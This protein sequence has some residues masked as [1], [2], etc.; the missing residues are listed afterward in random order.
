MSTAMQTDQC[1]DPTG[2]KPPTTEADLETQTGKEESYALEERTLNSLTLPIGVQRSGQSQT[3]D[4]SV[5]TS[6]II[7]SMGVQV[8]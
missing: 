3:L 1:Q 8:R 2:D 5:I 6:E 4:V 7:W